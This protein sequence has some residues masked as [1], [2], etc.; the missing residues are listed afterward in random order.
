MNKLS[1]V[2]SFIVFSAISLLG[3]KHGQAQTSLF[4]TGGSTLINGNYDNVFVGQ[5]ASGH[6]FDGIGNPYF[7]IANFVNGAAGTNT[8]G[9]YN[10]NA[11]II[12][13]SGGNVPY[14]DATDNSTINIS[15]GN[16]GRSAISYHNSTINISG[17]D[18]YNVVGEGTVNISGGTTITA[19]NASTGVLNIS[20]GNVITTAANQFC[21]TNISGGTIG[22][23][24]GH[25]HSTTNISGGSIQDLFGYENSVFNIS[26]GTISTHTIRLLP[27]SNS[28]LNIYGSNFTLSSMGSDFDLYGAYSD[29][30]LSGIFQDG[31][32]ITGVHL[33]DY[34]SS[35]GDPGQGTGSVRFLASSAAPE[36]STL[37]LLTLGAVLI[38]RRRSRTR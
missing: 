7:A 2:S 13:I 16:I 17:G 18:I 5:D 15:G 25:D 1:R 33:H 36:P 32:S 12:N 11:C 8:G 27:S 38:L 37:G 21:T 4:L 22:T 31:Q 34:S 3:T 24:I 9:I 28:T 26:G 6:Q 14:V 20:A 10:K 19:G 29:Y 30:L 23:V 35:V